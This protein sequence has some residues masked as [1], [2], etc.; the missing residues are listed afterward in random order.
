MTKAVAHDAAP[1]PAADEA[2]AALEIRELSVTYVA[3][4]ASPVHAVRGVSFEMRRGEILGLVGE[5]GCGKTAL[6]LSVLGLERRGVDTR[7]GGDILLRGESLVHATEDRRRQLRRTALG[8]VFQDPMTSLNP[9]MRVGRQVAEATGSMDAALVLLEEVGIAPAAARARA[10]PHQLSGGQRQRIMLAMAMAG[11]PE[12][13][14]A[15]EPT[16]ALDVTVQGQ[17]L[18]L[19]SRLRDEMSC[20]FLLITHD[21]GVAGQICDRIAVIYAGEIVELGP[22]GDVLTE[23]A[24]PYTR[25]LLASRITVRSPLRSTLSTLRGEPPDA[26][27]DIRGCVFA[28]R[29]PSRIDICDSSKPGLKPSGA[30]SARRVACLRHPVEESRASLATDDAAESM[31]SVAAGHDRGGDADGAVSVRAAAKHYSLRQGWFASSRLM[32]LEDV[33]LNIAAGESVAVV[34]ETGS[35]KTTLLRAV[36]GLLTLDAG[37]AHV[38]GIG[39]PQVVF[40]DAASSLTPWRSVGAHLHERLEAAGVDNDEHA[41]RIAEVLNF[42]GLGAEVVACR[43]HQLSGGQLQR[44]TLARAIVVPP[45]V[46]LCDEPTSSLDVSLAALVLNLINRLRRELRLAV[47]FVTH[48]LGAARAVSDRI[49][50]L[51]QGHIVERG[52]TELVI[53][54]PAHPYTRA[55][56]D[57]VPELGKQLGPPPNDEHQWRAERGVMRAVDDAGLHFAALAAEGE[58]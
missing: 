17:I 11:E 29:C 53:S 40:Q 34:G 14:V 55:L 50:V 24:H 21:L 5:S 42:V 46:L 38:G 26:H 27:S 3:R 47:L 44:V 9:T 57:A 43:P 30:M 31:P 16:T 41:Q 49:V 37:I 15:D 48:D 1:R 52:P 2:S 28:E 7:I 4:G 8:A 45:S 12:L 13:V 20:A 23:P 33:D 25:G 54:D 19:M 58:E 32:A 10:Y 22:V 39:G 56:L 35:G 36:A 6:G 51:Y 18:R